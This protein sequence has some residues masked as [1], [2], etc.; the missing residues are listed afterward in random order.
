MRR[1]HVSTPYHQNAQRICF[2]THSLEMDYVIK[3]YYFKKNCSELIQHHGRSAPDYLTVNLKMRR[4]HTE[5]LCG[6]D[7]LL[8]DGIRPEEIPY[9]PHQDLYHFHRIGLEFRPGPAYAY[10]RCHHK[11]TRHH[12]KVSQS[13]DYFNIVSVRTYFFFTFAQRCRFII[14]TGFRFSSGQTHLTTVGAK[15]IGTER[16]RKLNRV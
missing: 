15:V 1:A 14:L 16:K 9:I 8:L 11:I 10:Y 5:L 2:V 7:F 12:K 4:Q 3:L 6:Q 13:S